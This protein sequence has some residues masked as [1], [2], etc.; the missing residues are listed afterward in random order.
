MLSDEYMEMKRIQL[1]KKWARM[2]IAMVN[3]R[4]ELENG[5][6]KNAWKRGELHEALRDLSRK[7][8]IGY[9]RDMII[10]TLREQTEKNVIYPDDIRQWALQ[11]K[12]RRP[13]PECGT[14]ALDLNPMS[15]YDAIVWVMDFDDEPDDYDFR[16]ILDQQLQNDFALRKALK[17]NR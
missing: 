9:V 12:A 14:W 16:A 5:E 1:E 7:C 15:V 6:I 11:T 17:T 8:N 10:L 3:C 13:E 2:R 4:A